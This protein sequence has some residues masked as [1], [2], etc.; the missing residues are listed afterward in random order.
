VSATP[1]GLPIYRI[2]TGP[3]DDKFC[4]RVSA[5]LELGYELYGSPAAT[6]DGSNVIVAQALV[7]PGAVKNTN[8]R[9][10]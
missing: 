7:W 2:L 3:D 1:D 10:A 4:R 8:R 6:F 9:N 5:A